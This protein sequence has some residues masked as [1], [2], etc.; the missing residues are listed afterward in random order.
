MRESMLFA[1]PRELRAPRTECAALGRRSARRPA[2]V[3]PQR[4]TA[5][6][7]S[8]SVRSCRRLDALRQ[9]AHGRDQQRAGQA[10]RTATVR[11]C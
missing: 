7:S 3:R 5:G 6:R 2:V 4:R 9:P 8:A 10:R 1:L 11:L